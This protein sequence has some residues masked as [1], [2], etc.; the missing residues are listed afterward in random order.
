MTVENSDAEEQKANI[1]EKLQAFV[2]ACGTEGD[3]V[4]TMADE[5]ANSL[6]ISDLTDIS[7]KG[8]EYFR[9]TDGHVH[10]MTEAILKCKMSVRVVSLRNHRITD[11][12]AI[13]L[14]Q[15]ILPPSVDMLPLL[16]L[17]LEGNDIESTGCHALR[18]CLQSAN[19][20][21]QLLNLS[22]NPI[23][24]EGGF[25][26]SEAMPSNHSLTTLKLANC[27]LNL[28]TLVALT[29]SLA[30]NVSITS[31]NLDRPILSTKQEES[32]DHLSRVLGYHPTL[33]SLSLRHGRVSC[34]GCLLFSQELVTNTTLLS[35]NLEC[36]CIGIKGAEALASYLMEVDSLQSLRLTSNRIC[37][38]G[39]IA[40]ASAIRVNK[41]L[42]E[43]T[44]R[45]NDIG[46]DGLVAIGN[47]LYKNGTLNELSLWGNSFD[48]VSCGLF[49]DLYESRIPY[50]DLSLD[51][52]IYI[53]DGIHC[54]A[55]KSL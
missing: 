53:V 34:H 41:S 18:E 25:M 51:C 10:I 54:V 44:L 12:G 17:D 36:N 38:D 5:V 11:V 6:Q 55:E 40:M 31:L 13:Q 4:L 30:S 16:E 24:S 43:L 20:N 23:S 37:N 35:L 15:L 50:V 46:Q 9:F 19:C 21:L 26:L 29:T 22:W 14:C 3:G 45:H 1:D 39:A 42:S 52:Q 27:D 7:I 28:S 47:S 32:A 33:R 8:C 2:E 49:H 48:D